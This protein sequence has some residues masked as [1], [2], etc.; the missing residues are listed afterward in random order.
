[1]KKGVRDNPICGASLRC[2]DTCIAA[3]KL[4]GF[5]YSTEKGGDDLC[6]D[7]LVCKFDKATSQ[8]DEG[9]DGLCV[10]K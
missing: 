6:E 7:G 2:D 3:S 4:G 5:C 8:G 10:K 9:Y 1:V